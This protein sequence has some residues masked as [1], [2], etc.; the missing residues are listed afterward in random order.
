MIEGCSHRIVLALH[1]F[2]VSVV[3]HILIIQRSPK[4]GQQVVFAQRCIE[5][6]HRQV[7][8]ENG[9]L[10]LAQCILLVLGV[11]HLVVVHLALGNRRNHVTNVV[12]DF[13]LNERGHFDGVLEGCQSIL[14]IQLFD[15][16]A[17]ERLVLFNP[18]L[19][20]SEFNR[21]DIDQ[22][23][24]GHCTQQLGSHR[25]NDPIDIGIIAGL[26]GPESHVLTN[27]DG[28]RT[29]S[30][31]FAHAFSQLLDQLRGALENRL[32]QT[33]HLGH[34]RF[35]HHTGERVRRQEPLHGSQGGLF[36]HL[37]LVDQ[38]ATLTQLGEI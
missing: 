36:K 9:L 25:I 27:L 26:D 2:Q 28:Q 33:S 20:R 22:S 8:Q 38:I 7:Q 1:R 4:Q 34:I 13:G 29:L 12:G 31:N 15:D 17:I 30:L 24:R 21:A 37:R 14:V 5:A 11:G 3:E 6:D 19:G 18:V 16:D 35:I 32:R 10:L 23:G